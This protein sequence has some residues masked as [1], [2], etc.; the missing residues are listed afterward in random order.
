MQ[1]ITYGFPSCAFLLHLS[2]EITSD[3]FLLIAKA[4]G[5]YLP[6]PFPLQKLGALPG[7]CNVQSLPLAF[8][9][10]SSDSHVRSLSQKILKKMSALS[11]IIT[12]RPGLCVDACTSQS[13]EKVFSLI[14]MIIPSGPTDILIFLQEASR[15]N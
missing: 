1:L 7:F 9:H 15:Q 5:W 8:F 11:N 12:G 14:N 13:S 10:V 2:P 6:D 4:P 3:H